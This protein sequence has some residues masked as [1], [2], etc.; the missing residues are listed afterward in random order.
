[1][2]QF[3][4]NNIPMV[5]AAG[6]E[7]DMEFISSFLSD[8]LEDAFSLPLRAPWRGNEAALGHI[9]ELSLRERVLR[10]ENVQCWH[11]GET[12][13]VGVFYVEHSDDEGV[14]LSFSVE[15]FIS[16]LKEKK[17]AELDLGAAITV[18]DIRAHAKDVSY[19]MW[20]AAPYAFPMHYNPEFYDSDANPDWF[21]E[22]RE[23]ESGSSY[24]VNDI[25][26]VRQ[27]G[28]VGR[29]WDFQCV[30]AIGV[31]TTPPG[32]GGDTFN[33]RRVAFGLVNHWD[34]EN[35]EYFINDDDGN[36]FNLVPWFYL[37]EMLTRAAAA[38]GYTVAGDFMDDARYHGRV[39]YN[40]Y[41][42]DGGRR[43]LYFRAAMA[44]PAAHTLYDTAPFPLPAA[45][46]SIAPNADVDGVWD[47]GAFK[48]VVQE[49]GTYKFKVYVKQY[50]PNLETGG[51][52]DCVMRKV[53]TDEFYDEVYGQPGGSD[54]FS[55]T[56]AVLD[57]P[58]WFESIK[59]FGAT[60]PA[61]SIGEEWY[62]DIASQEASNY[63]GCWV[64]GWKV[65]PELVN[66]Y[67]NIIRPKDHA[68]D[69]SFGELLLSLRDEFRL[70]VA[71][72]NGELRLDY[73]RGADGTPLKDLTPQLRSPVSIDSSS[74]HTGL[75]INYDVET[76]DI[77]DL[78]KL[79]DRG[80][81]AIE[82]Q[83][84]P[85][86]GPGEYAV[87][88]ATRQLYVSEQVT[89]DPYF[90]WIPRGW[91]MPDRT[92]GE[93]TNAQEIK[94]LFGPLFGDIV[95]T[96]GKQLLVPTISEPGQSSYFRTGLNLPSLRM[97]NY[98]GQVSTW[99]YPTEPVEV[100][101]RYPYA[102]SFGFAMGG[103]I[104]G[105]APTEMDFHSRIGPLDLHWLALA[106]A[107][108]KAEILELD[109]EVDP[110]L[111]IDRGYELMVML[112]FQRCLIESLPVTYGD[113]RQ[114]LISRG[115][116]LLKLQLP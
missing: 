62:F 74:A 3:R 48:W 24:A 10:I 79:L 66:T 49:A 34:W 43:T 54:Q 47:N 81:F 84:P 61:G 95:D 96:N 9:H 87:V 109:I 59:T 27:A 105:S 99:P 22:R 115:A 77:P 14:D 44:S 56:N 112:H 6:T 31:S 68:P 65:D 116:R 82:S 39:I 70:R 85:P 72:I 52:C 13:H 40:N 63:A 108:A 76:G 37:K 30:N 45:D 46:D 35:E 90:V 110:S 73:L 100:Q 4:I 2:L 111:I 15:G 42:L 106:I 88:L 41:A 25:V 98:I 19:L 78:A 5:L 80:F 38:F 71:P 26:T 97:T 89:Y 53:G 91:Y 92:F 29:T 57:Q 113:D 86:Y 101:P 114:R 103:R 36:F 83:L 32:P 7:A 23:W 104:A 11:D 16:R 51:Y 60:F 50:M 69:C 20:P 1:M 107:L 33:F 75:T 93:A 21:P 55:P 28:I 94:V 64:Q 102:T 18:A 17:M 58:H 12:R 8:G 67:V